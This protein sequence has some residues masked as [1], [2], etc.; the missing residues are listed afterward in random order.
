MGMSL[1][2]GVGDSLTS[3]WGGGGGGWVNR[4]AES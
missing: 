1:E 4:V 2:A 3:S